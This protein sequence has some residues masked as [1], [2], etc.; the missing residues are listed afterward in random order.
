MLTIERLDCGRTALSLSTNS[1]TNLYSGQFLNIINEPCFMIIPDSI[2][3]DPQQ[4]ASACNAL[5]HSQPALSP[6]DA[7]MPCATPNAPALNLRIRIEYP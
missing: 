2:S 4:R 5:L 1:A 6:V 7:D 3:S